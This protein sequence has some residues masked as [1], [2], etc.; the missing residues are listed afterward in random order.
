MCDHH[1][2]LYAHRHKRM[3]V[4]LV[5]SERTLWIRPTLAARFG[6][7]RLQRTS[8]STHHGV[9]AERRAPRPPYPLFLQPPVNL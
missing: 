7:V 6:I 5:R 8:P 9:G 4:A 2:K 1:T 3:L